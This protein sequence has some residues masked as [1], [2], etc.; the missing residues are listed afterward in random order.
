M[1]SSPNADV[2]V[3]MLDR[4]VQLARLLR[5][6]GVEVSTG[7]LIDAAHALGHLDVGDRSA[8][9]AGLRATMVK[10]A[11]AAERFDRLFDAVFRAASSLAD[12]QPD[13]R[14]R[15]APL[16]APV[17]AA[18]SVPDAV[19]T[20]LRSGDRDALTLLAAQ[21]V[22]LYAGLDGMEGSERYF[23]HRVLRALDLSRMLSAANRRRN[24]S[25]RRPSSLRSRASCS[26][27]RSPSRRSRCIAAESR[28]DKSSARSTRWRK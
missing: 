3:P 24:S 27:V 14:G 18:A 15:H 2:T 22:D 12:D 17:A 9:R 26:S 11:G 19:L 4:V 7:E 8:L 1:R 10:E 28:R 13:E 5:R 20:A 25:S 23:L 16:S 6:S 21:A